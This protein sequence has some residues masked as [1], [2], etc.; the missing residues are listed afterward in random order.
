MLNTTNISKIDIID[1]IRTKSNMA[2]IAIRNY[3]NSLEKM[4]STQLESSLTNSPNIFIQEINSDYLDIFPNQHVP[5]L[6]SFFLLFNDVNELDNIV[7]TGPYIR[8][9]L[10]YNECE[11]THNNKIIRNEIYVHKLTFKKWKELVDITQFENIKGEYVTYINNIKISLIKSTYKSL[12]HIIIQHDYLKRVGW[13]NNKFITSY[14]FLLELQKHSDLMEK[15][16]MDP[17][18][19]VP[20][21][22]CQIYQSYDFDNTDLKILIDR[23]DFN[24]IIKLDESQITKIYGTKTCIELCIEK[25]INETNTIVIE[26]LLKIFHHLIQFQ[27]QRPPYLHA[28]FEQL[29]HKSPE[30]AQIILNIPL[31]YK[32]LVKY[33]NNDT[34]FN[35]LFDVDY[36]IINC[37]IKEDKPNDLFRYCSYIK[38]RLTKTIIDKIIKHKSQKIINKLLEKNMLDKNLLYY[39][40]LMSESTDLL[41]KYFIIPKDASD[42]TVEMQN[43]NE[44]DMSIIINYITE[45]LKNGLYKIFKYMYNIDNSI[46]TYISED[47]QTVLH[48]ISENGNYVDLINFIINN[49]PEI[50]NFVNN[51]NETPLLYHSKKNSN[52]T[53]I[54]LN[55]DNDPTICD[56]Y[57][58][59]FIHNLCGMN[60]IK[61]IQKSCKKYP[62]IINLPNSSSETPI[63][64]CCKNGF[65]DL[66]YII[67]GYG[68]TLDVKDNYG[69]TPYHYMCSTGICIGTTIINSKNNF[70]KTP[71]DYCKLCPNFW[72]FAE[73]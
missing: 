61:E 72:N 23:V 27:C 51:N 70:Y 21:D 11:K 20:Y 35:T 43:K 52:I 13:Y 6:E 28:C 18:L 24:Q 15:G 12:S 56:I 31:Q 46:I 69:N 34:Y 14:M 22:P 57:G 44:F 1:I 9:C 63:L 64:I 10:L 60:F 48:L 16:F 19:L 33:I 67:K 25:Y 65:E 37:I 29:K 50:L 36:F 53:N 17:V 40:V 26:E 41:Q 42:C 59:T 58:N 55:Y 8:S 62:E 54:I 30:L 32:Y 38:Q 71:Y 47:N 45:I 4:F 73:N 2:H 3:E 49:N 39:I 7:V 68:G 66:Y 5:N